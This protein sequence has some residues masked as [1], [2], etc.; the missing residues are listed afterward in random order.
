VAN[1][2]GSKGAVIDALEVLEQV[3]AHI[4][5]QIPGSDHESA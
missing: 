3:L 5:V 1:L 4:L 2:P